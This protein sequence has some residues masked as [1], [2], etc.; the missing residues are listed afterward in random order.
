MSALRCLI[1]GLMLVLPLAAAAQVYKWQDDSGRWHY[2]DKPRDGAK[3]VDLAPVQ[4][5]EPP[6]IPPPRR[7][8]QEEQPESEPMLSYSRI[9]ILS[10]G[11]GE[12]IREPSGNIGVI[13]AMEPTLRSGHKVRLL[14][15]GKPVAGPAESTAFTLEHVDRGEHSIS[16]EILDENGQ[17]IGRSQAQTFYLHRPSRLHVPGQRPPVRSAP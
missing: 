8:P 14:L 4:V 16:V 6:S 7:A 17:R 11:E 13:V 9:A 2:T 3:P 15:D 1:I 10:P 5:Y 12:T